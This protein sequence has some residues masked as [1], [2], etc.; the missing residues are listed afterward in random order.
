MSRRKQAKPRALKSDESEEGEAVCEAVV[1][2]A[3]AGEAQGEA[4]Q[5]MSAPLPPV[6]LARAAPLPL[7]PL[8]ISEDV[9]S[10]EGLKRAL[11]N[12]CGLQQLSGFADA[13]FGK[14]SPIDDVPLPQPMPLEGGGGPDGPEAAP[15][16]EEAGKRAAEPGE[17]ADSRGG[18]APLVSRSAPTPTPSPAHAPYPGHLDDNSLESDALGTDPGSSWRSETPEDATSPSPSSCATP[19]SA[20][21]V[22][23][24]EL[25]F[26]VGVT[27]GTPYACSFCDKAFPRLSY[28]KKHE[29]THSDQMPFRCEFCSR[30]FKHKRSRDRHIKLHTGD[31]KYRCTQCEAAFSRSIKNAVHSVMKYEYIC[32]VTNDKHAKYH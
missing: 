26:T 22:A 28:L 23:D 7:G 20:T 11:L 24:S 19:N 17:A 4:M 18:G 9:D 29:Q 15:G 2:E 31:K 32:K 12:R 30:L 5:A 27:E 8:T 1:G 16:A 21:D 13:L 3:P 14:R 25:A 6:Q 10:V